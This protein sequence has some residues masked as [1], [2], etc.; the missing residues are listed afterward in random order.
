MAA[1]NA[2]T[3]RAVLNWLHETMFDSWDRTDFRRIL[4]FVEAIAAEMM[5]LIRDDEAKFRMMRTLFQLFRG[6]SYVSGKR[7]LTCAV[8]KSR[9]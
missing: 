4:A 3:A 1:E 6:Y 9:P 7:I 5:L 2:S 8:D